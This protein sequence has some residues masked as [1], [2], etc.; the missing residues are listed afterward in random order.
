V[1]RLAEL[2]KTP[3]LKGAV[4]FVNAKGESKTFASEADAEAA[5]K[6]IELRHERGSFFEVVKAAAK[7]AAPASPPKAPAPPAAG[8]KPGAKPSEDEE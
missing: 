4:L 3:R 5:L 7:A 1:G 6:G 2:A 8:A